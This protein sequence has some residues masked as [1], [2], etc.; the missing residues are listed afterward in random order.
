MDD[1]I[2][3]MNIIF[4]EELE[5]NQKSNSIIESSLIISSKVSGI[6]T[7]RELAGSQ[8]ISER[9]LNRLFNEYIGMSAKMFL[10]LVRINNT[11][12]ILKYTDYNLADNAQIL[13]FYDQSHFIKDF[14]AI[15]GVTPK[16]FMENMSDF[17]NEEF[18]Y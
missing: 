10:K 11:I 8:Y 2:T 7:I 6:M 16:S 13:G 4:I 5:K 18:K 15:C 14:K 12:N 9:Q 3:S 1:L 17:Y